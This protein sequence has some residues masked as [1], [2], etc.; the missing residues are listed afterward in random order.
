MAAAALNSLYDPVIVTDDAGRIV[1]LNQAAE[2][3]FGSARLVEN[4]PVADVVREERIAKAIARAIRQVRVSAEEGEEA[5]VPL[6]IGSTQRTYRLRATPMRDDE[7]A[8][9]GAAAVLEDVT[10]LRELDRLKSE[11]ISVASHELRTPVTSL[12]L[13]AQL[14]QEGA[15]GPLTP[16]QQEV[17]AAQREDLE[18]L[19]RTMRDLLDLTRLE[20]GVVPP[21]LEMISPSEIVQA[22]V[23][24]VAS[25]VEAK[26][27]ALALEVP[28][29]LPRVRADRVQITRVLINL[30]N[31]AVR[32]TP[33]AGHITL[34]AEAQDRHVL[35]RVTD[36]GPG[37]PREYLPH[38]FER[39]VQVPG[40]TPG[41]TG[42]GLSIAQT[43]VRAHGG[44]MTVESE[45]GQGST[46]TFLLPTTAPPEGEPRKEPPS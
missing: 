44:E 23:A 3:L 13:S 35:F 6:S 27:I 34:Q 24:S 1:H 11:F 46:F 32:H 5:F 22:A 39:F 17:V 31:N 16:E 38:I 42:L 8:L 15:V 29:D 20:T 18:R 40:A 21:R 26:G 36:T 33:E 7:G 12:L 25:Q 2:G 30:L 45:I 4:Q 41:G 37:I 14:L 9:L 10:H 43:I 19:E 28:E